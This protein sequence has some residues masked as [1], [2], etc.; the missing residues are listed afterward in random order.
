MDTTREG[1]PGFVSLQK[2]RSQILGEGKERFEK[3]R[4]ERERER[5]ISFCTLLYICKHLHFMC[6]E[7]R[8]SSG[9]IDGKIN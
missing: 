7:T 5:D 8:S 6:K 4:E 2:I 9:F 3:E 1:I